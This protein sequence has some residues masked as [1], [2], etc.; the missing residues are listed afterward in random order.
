MIIGFRLAGRALSSTLNP[1]VAFCCRICRTLCHSVRHI[2][3]H[4]HLFYQKVKAPKSAF[5]LAQVSNTLGHFSTDVGLGC[6]MPHE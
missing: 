3:Y 4:G 6:H 5:K 1:Y 2:I